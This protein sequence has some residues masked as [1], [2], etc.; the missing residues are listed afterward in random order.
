MYVRQYNIMYTHPVNSS[1]IHKSNKRS[2]DMREGGERKGE[3]GANNL[4]IYYGDFDFSLF[5]F[6]S[7]SLFLCFSFYRFI[8]L[9][10]LNRGMMSLSLWVACLLLFLRIEESIIISA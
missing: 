10:L 5:L 1:Y 9:S 3:G 8:V 6:F 7:F 4:L 2:L